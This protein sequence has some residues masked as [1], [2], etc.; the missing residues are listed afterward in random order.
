[1]P[2]VE[3]QLFTPVTL[4]ATYAKFAKKQEYESTTTDDK[5]E[6]EAK[7]ASKDG[8]ERQFPFRHFHNPR[9]ETYATWGRLRARDL[10]TSSL[11]SESKTP[12]NLNRI[13]TMSNRTP[14]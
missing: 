11:T 14:C 2:E 10:S 5:T 12:R 3:P 1:V 7:I 8:G 6:S 9:I 4:L 13:R